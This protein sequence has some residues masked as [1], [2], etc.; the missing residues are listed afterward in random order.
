VGEKVAMHLRGGTLLV[1]LEDDGA[2]I[3]GPAETVFG[4]TLY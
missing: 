3:E 4:G 1:S 2:W